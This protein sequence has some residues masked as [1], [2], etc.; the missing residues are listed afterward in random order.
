MYIGKNIASLRKQ[1]GLS[2]E[3][4]AEKLGVSRQAVAKWESNESYPELPKLIHMGSLFQVSMDSLLQE[5]S[6]YTFSPEEARNNFHGLGT[7]KS[8]LQSFLCK[9][10]QETY[11]AGRGVVASSR[12][13]SH[14]LQYAEGNLVYLDSYVG[15]ERFSG[16]EVV[17]QDGVPIWSMN[18]TGRVVADPF[19]GD[20]LKEALALVST[21]R[22]YCGPAHYQKGDYTYLCMV[23]GDLSWFSG[24]EEIFCSG[25]KVYELLFHGG[26]VKE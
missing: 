22:P 10:K 4:F 11:A 5:P 24:K 15:S 20:F 25:I 2:Q 6:K 21:E 13:A 23:D 9:A 19:S 3:S 12:E 7:H 18:Y 16:E 8:T 1:V 14:D 17:W 26:Y